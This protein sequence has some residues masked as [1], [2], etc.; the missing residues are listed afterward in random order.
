MDGGHA[1]VVHGFDH[2]LS[3]YVS[4]VTPALLQM[5][6]CR[7]EAVAELLEEA[8]DS[9]ITDD[10]IVCVGDVIDTSNQ[11]GFLRCAGHA[12]CRCQGW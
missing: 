7:R 4:N 6:S 3:R 5:F 1:V 12:V 8:V 10:R 11:D 9:E 2:Q